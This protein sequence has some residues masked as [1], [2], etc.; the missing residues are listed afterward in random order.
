MH[1]YDCFDLAY[2]H[3]AITGYLSSIEQLSGANFGKWKKQISI[4]LGVMDLDYAL[5]V[6]APPSLTAE[7]SAEQK[8]AYDKWE[9][10]NCISLMI[11]KGS[12]TN[13]ICRAIPNSDNAKIYLADV[14]E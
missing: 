2:S 14:E 9:R 11:M 13:A 8:A 7:S 10:F 4:I 3:A 6:D 1:D 5:W 12:I